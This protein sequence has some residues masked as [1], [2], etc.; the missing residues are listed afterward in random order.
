[1]SARLAAEN[2]EFVLQANGVEVARIDEVGRGRS[3][4]SPRPGRYRIPDRACSVLRA[5]FG[6]TVPGTT[7]SRVLGKGIPSPTAIHLTK[8]RTRKLQAPG[9][10]E[11]CA[12]YGHSFRY[13]STAVRIAR[14]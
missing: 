13:C 4:G 6:G 2:P 8:V 5:H 7:W 12:G 14:V 10:D 1:M 3:R 9:K 11:W